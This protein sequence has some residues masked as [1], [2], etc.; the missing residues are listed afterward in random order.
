MSTDTESSR[1]DVTPSVG[2]RPRS[3]DPQEGIEKALGLFHARGYD[4]VGTAEICREI[5]IKPP[6]LYA[7]YGSKAGLFE[8]VLD[9]YADTPHGRFVMDAIEEAGSADELVRNVLM[10]AARRYA[11]D[12]SCLGCLALESSVTGV[13]SEARRT[14]SSL[15]D[16]TQEL[17]RKAFAAFGDPE[18]ETKAGMTIVLMRGLSGAARSGATEE[19]LTATVRMIVDR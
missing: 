6:S 2:G 5:G 3:F 10:S 7:A 18:P 9:R 16:A 1:G 14:A 13:S 17:L 12:P 8:Q 15:A 19:E 4:G 11:A